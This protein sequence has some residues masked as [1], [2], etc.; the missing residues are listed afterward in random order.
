MQIFQ[1]STTDKDQLSEMVNIGISHA[2]TTLSRLLDHRIAISVPSVDVK[3]ARNVR[4]FIPLSSDITLAVLLRVTGGLEGYVFVLFPRDA[5]I[6][7]LGSLSGK[8]VGD[9]R[10]LDPFD[11][12]IFQEIGNVITGGMLGGLSKFLS[13]SLVHSVPEVVIDMG[14]AMFNSLVA[15]M[16]ASHDQFLALDVAICVDSPAEVACDDSRGMVGRVFFLIGPTVAEEI[17]SVMRGMTKN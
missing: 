13:L 2:G 11:R 15:S 17:L 1:L 14:G 7:L 9:L 4:E 16:I 12:S 6:H 8:T 3:D 5:S 10:A